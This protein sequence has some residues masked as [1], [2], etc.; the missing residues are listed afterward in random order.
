MKVAVFLDYANI[1]ASSR[2]L[3]CS[4]DYGALLDYLADEEEGRTLQAAY[5]YVPIDPRQEHARDGIINEL[6]QNG[7]IVKSKVGSI[8]GDSYKYDFDVEM[9]LDI[10]RMAYGNAPDTIVIVSGD[11]DFIPIVLDMRGRG[12][13][14]E[15]AAFGAAMSGQ[16]A[17]KSSGFINLDAII[18]EGAVAENFEQNAEFEGAE[19][20]LEGENDNA[21]NN[22]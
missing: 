18:G 4:V 6:W 5:A 20:V 16:L 11:N 9:T 19:D 10:S 14:V 12:I 8:A 3:N 21:A 2:Q 17:L 1:E 15:V 22:S 13:R 7:Y